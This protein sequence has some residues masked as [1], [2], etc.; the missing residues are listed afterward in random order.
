MNINRH[1]YEEYFLLYVDHELNA[2]ER[3]AVELF[4]QENP[5][6]REELRMLEQTVFRPE[7][8]IVFDDK[9]SL[10]KS[11]SDTQLINESN[12]EE[13]FI[14]YGDD[15]L[16][17][18]EKDSVEQ[19][20]YKNP[21]HQVNFELIQ[22]AR[23]SADTSI[24][25]PDK[26]SLYRTEK[27]ERVV[28]LRWWKIAVA[29]AVLFVV[30]TAVL[31][32]GGFIGQQS[33]NPPEMAIK[34]RG[35]EPSTQQKEILPN[36]TNQ[37][38]NN[39][40]NEVLVESSTEKQ[41]L[42]RSVSPNSTNKDNKDIVVP[43]NTVS[44]KQE[45]ELIAYTPES[46]K[47]SENESNPTTSTNVIPTV[48]DVAKNIVKAPEKVEPVV[49]S[50]AEADRDFAALN[51]NDPKDSQGLLTSSDNQIEVLTTSV[52]NKGKMRG[53]FRK[54]GRVVSKATNFGNSAEKDTDK[55]GV[56]I[57]NFEIALK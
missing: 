11:T 54:V 14:L 23:V 33:V 52:S 27:D 3:A 49:F 41:E 16:S 29:A 53:F 45:Q 32:F 7:K 2:D 43:V 35:V 10:L 20:V 50:S 48:K 24:V 40:T 44:P 5:D 31:Y 1:N 46:P 37:Q 28:V 25:F 21:Q 55:K 47:K 26:Q 15:E 56:R 42:K 38:P 34:N 57:A 22:Q 4:V 17:N 8:K 51:V 19:F 12:F 30:G 39:S 6:L 13:F 9:A 36:T 18:S